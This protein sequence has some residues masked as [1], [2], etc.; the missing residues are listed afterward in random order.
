MLKE[1]NSKVGWKLRNLSNTIGLTETKYYGIN[2]IGQ[3]GE[4][5]NKPVYVIEKNWAL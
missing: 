3:V 4:N 5:N 2:L 1:K